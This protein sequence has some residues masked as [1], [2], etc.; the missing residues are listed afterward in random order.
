VRVIR[1]ESVA[2][3][4]T[5]AVLALSALRLSDALAEDDYVRACQT[6]LS[7]A[8]PSIN[9]RVS[10]EFVERGETYRPGE[11]DNTTGYYARFTMSY[12]QAESEVT[13]YGDLSRRFARAKVDSP[14]IGLTSCFSATGER[15]LGS[16]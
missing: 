11:R 15:E 14:S 2:L 4:A 7:N 1:L 8:S 5:I 6:M 10:F 9:F 13:C 16:C 12:G 3:F